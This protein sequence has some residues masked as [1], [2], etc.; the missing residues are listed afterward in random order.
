MNVKKW[1]TVAGVLNHA[2]WTEYFDDSPL[3]TSLD[4]DELPRLSQVHYAAQN[5]KVVPIELTQHA[6]GDKTIILV[7]DAT[8]DNFGH[9]ELDFSY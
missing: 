2:D 6:A 5:D 9:L 3:S 1:I 8:H 4:M 7:P